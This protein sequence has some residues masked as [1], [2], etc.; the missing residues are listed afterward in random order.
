VGEVR[1]ET[2]R[3]LLRQPRIEDVSVVGELLTDPEV[4]RFLGG[5]TVPTE[6][7]PEVVQKWIG[8]WERD[9]VGPFVVERR[10]DGAFVGRTGLLVWETRTWTQS[11]LAEA[12]EHA[13]PEL[14][15]A[16]VQAHWGD[17]YA[18]EAARAVR[19]WAREERGVGRLVSLIALT[20]TASQR[21][22]ERLGARPER[23]VELFDSG[24][25]VMWV[26]P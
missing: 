2:R 11:S 1:L 18:T 7:I 20:N 25:A 16:L 12:G 6:A 24:E 19:G 10:E 3:L 9:D 23:T 14:G 22:A 8:R 26:H 13:Q 5:R 21:V 17:G 4:M 15:W